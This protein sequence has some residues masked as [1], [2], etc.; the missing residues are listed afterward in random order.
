[1]SCEYGFMGYNAIEGLALERIFYFYFGINLF[2]ILPHCS[3]V[4]K[5]WF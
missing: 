5:F 2:L 1:M 3:F 4:P